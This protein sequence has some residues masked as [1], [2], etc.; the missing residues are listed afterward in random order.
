M[1]IK[2]I[3]SLFQLIQKSY[4]FFDPSDN[5]KIPNTIILTSFLVKGLKSAFWSFINTFNIEKQPKTCN[6]LPSLK[7]QKKLVSKPFKKNF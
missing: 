5:R 7:K 3:D 2:I 1:A 4:L 6:V